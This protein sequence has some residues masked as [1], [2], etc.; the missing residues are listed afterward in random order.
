MLAVIS[1]LILSKPVH[2]VVHV[3]ICCADDSFDFMSD[4]ELNPIDD[5]V[6]DY[7]PFNSK[8]QALLFFLLHSPRPM[9]F[10]G[11]IHVNMYSTL[12]VYLSFIFYHLW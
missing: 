7:A 4:L 8:V 2:Y 6:V 1:Y 10:D 3:N 9:V 12:F 11:V 5:D